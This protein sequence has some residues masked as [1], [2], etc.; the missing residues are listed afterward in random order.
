MYFNKPHRKRTS[1]RKLSL[2]IWRRSAVFQ[3]VHWAGTL[4]TLPGRPLL[5]IWLICASTMPASGLR[6]PDRSISPQWT[7]DSMI[8]HFFIVSSKRNSAKPHVSICWK[9]VTDT[10]RKSC[11]LLWKW[12]LFIFNLLLMLILKNES[13]FWSPKAPFGDNLCNISKLT[14]KFVRAFNLRPQGSLGGLNFQNKGLGK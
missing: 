6:K 8:S 13:S 3:V 14:Y 9:I 10:N 11:H 12:L 5:N 4:K 1:I 7:Q 2:M